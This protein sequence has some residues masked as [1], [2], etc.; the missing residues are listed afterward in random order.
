M[1]LEL[2]HLFELEHLP[3][4]SSGHAQWSWLWLLGGV[5][6]LF[7]I[8]DGG[9]SAMALLVFWAVGFVVLKFALRRAAARPLQGYISGRVGIA[10]ATWIA[11]AAQIVAIQL[12]GLAAIVVLMTAAW[13]LLLLIVLN[14]DP[15]HV[16]QRLCGVLMASTLSLIHI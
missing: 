10:A 8:S 3:Q 13:V 5:G 1:T 4:E 9:R 14:P 15:A 7:A 11:I 12:G 6:P 2:E 16:R